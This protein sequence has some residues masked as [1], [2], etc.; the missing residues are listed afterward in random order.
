MSSHE[1]HSKNDKRKLKS[2]Q[3]PGK[4]PYEKVR[5]YQSCIPPSLNTTANGTLLPVLFI[6]FTYCLGTPI[7]K[8]MF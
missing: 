8:N 6:D 1:E 3:N 5:L 2:D 4:I 7:S